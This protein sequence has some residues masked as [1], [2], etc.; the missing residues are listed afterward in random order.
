M[1]QVNVFIDTLVPLEW[2]KL[3]MNFSSRKVQRVMLGGLF[4]RNY[5]ENGPVLDSNRHFLIAS[6]VCYPFTPYGC[7]LLNLASLITRSH[8]LC[9]SSR[10]H[11]SSQVYVE[12][13]ELLVKLCQAYLIQV[14]IGCSLS[15]FQHVIWK[16]KY[17][18]KT[19]IECFWMLSQ[20]KASSG[21][22][23]N[24]VLKWEGRSN[25]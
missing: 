2:H 16:E 21:F 12:Q 17:W 5:C 8:V 25:V 19:G 13:V 4:K 20:Y 18:P 11:F 3:K 9:C 15:T 23:K 1:S 10:L 14:T 7:N 6:L 22:K 24:T